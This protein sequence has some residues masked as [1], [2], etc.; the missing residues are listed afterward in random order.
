MDG[1]GQKKAADWWRK[2]TDKLRVNACCYCWDWTLLL[3]V[4][5]MDD[6]WMN[7]TGR[8]L[9][10]WIGWGRMGHGKCYWKKTEDRNGRAFCLKPGTSQSVGFSLLVRLSHFSI[11]KLFTLYLGN[12]THLPVFTGTGHFLSRFSPEFPP[13]SP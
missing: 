12:M 1:W 9:H 5:G 3:K 10:G 11:L 4:K 8:I 13:S 6:G 7:G 2:C